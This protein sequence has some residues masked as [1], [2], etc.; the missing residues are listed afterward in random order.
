MIE[1]SFFSIID[2][3]DAKVRKDMMA[4]YFSRAAIL[5]LESLIQE[6]ITKFLEVLSTAASSKKVVDLNLGFSC[7][8]ADVVMHYCY[9]KTFGALDAPDFQFRPI[10]TIEEVFDA[11]PYTW[12]FPQAF[13]ILDFVTKKLPED[14]VHKYMPPIAATTWIQRVCHPIFIS[15]PPAQLSIAL[16]LMSQTPAMPKPRPRSERRCQEPRPKNI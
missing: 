10:V 7:L 2:H 3:K 9:Q 14:L 6:K 13:K 8:A 15:I 11:A 16:A 1:A 12:Y 5:R 4:P